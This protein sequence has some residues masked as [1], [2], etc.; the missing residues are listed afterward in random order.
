[1]N[2]SLPSAIKLQKSITPFIFSESIGKR[3]CLYKNKRNDALCLDLLAGISNQYFRVV[4]KNYDKANY[5]ILNPDVNLNVAGLF[6]AASLVYTIPKKTGS[7]IIK[8]NVQTPP[9]AI[10]GDYPLSYELCAPL[11]LTVGYDLFYGKKRK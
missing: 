11:Q 3:I 9:S 6:L 2:P 4:Y 10:R 8:L 7:L 1:L 5:D